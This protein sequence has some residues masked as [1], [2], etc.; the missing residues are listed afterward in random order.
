VLAELPFAT[1]IRADI[2]PLTAVF[3][4]LFFASVGS[5]VAV[6]LAP[7][8]LAAVA[9][10]SIAVILWKALI[11]DVATWLVQR[12]MR[13][14]IVTGLTVAQVGEFAFVI[15]ETAH[16]N[17]AFP[18]ALFQAALA[19]SLITLMATPF[20]IGSAPGLAARFLRSV[21][22]RSRSALEPHRTGAE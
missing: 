17:G 20:L 13:N 9:G 19:V 18:D 1:Q 2:T 15:A 7:V 11:E 14:A 6:P 21:P 10:I 12:S 16:G 22:A 5:A 4:T 8:Y 3:V